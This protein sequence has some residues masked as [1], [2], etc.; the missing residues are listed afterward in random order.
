M[1]KEINKTKIEKGLKK[2][3]KIYSLALVGI[4]VLSL[5]TPTVF[6]AG[7]DPI[8]VVNNLSDFIFQLTKIIGGIIVGYA[9]VQIGLS[10]TSHDASQRANGFLFFAGGVIIMCAKTILN[11]IS[12]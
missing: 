5:L 1:K 12:S 6:A 2:G 9:I 4:G 11:M 3:F 8:T 7:D 10:F